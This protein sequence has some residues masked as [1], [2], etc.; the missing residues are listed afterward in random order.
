MIFSFLGIDATIFSNLMLRKYSINRSD[1]IIFAAL[2][3]FISLTQYILLKPVMST[4]LALDDWGAILTIESMMP[5]TIDK[6]LNY[7]WTYLGIH[8]TMQSFY[9]TTLFNFFNFNYPVYNIAGIILKIISI[10]SIFPVIYLI[11][12]RKSLAFLTT[13]I[14]AISYSATGALT[15]LLQ[16]IYYLG[17][18]FMNIFFIF[19]YFT[20]TKNS[21][22]YSILACLSLILAYWFAP[23]RI[24]PILLFILIVELFLNLKYGFKIT[25][26]KSLLRLFLFYTPILLLMFIGK[27]DYSQLGTPSQTIQDVYNGNW[28]IILNPFSGL[29]YLFLSSDYW[30]LFNN[31]NIQGFGD[32]LRFLIKENLFIILPFSVFFSFILKK[33]IIKYSFLILGINFV[34]SIIIYF[35]ATHHLSIPINLRVGWDETVFWR[36]Q[37]YSLFGVYVLTISGFCF[38]EYTKIKNNGNLLLIAISVGPILSL[39]FLFG[40]WFILGRVMTFYSGISRY[41]PFSSL[42]ASL[43]VAAVLIQAYDRVSKASQGVKSVTKIIIFFILVLIFI[44]SSKE[45]DLS[46][47]GSNVRNSYLHK[48][49]Q[50]NFIN[51]LDIKELKKKNN[52]LFYFDLAD[53]KQKKYF[54]EAFDLTNFGRWMYLRLEEKG[55][56]CIGS[57]D[58]EVKLKEAI[59]AGS[60]GYILFHPNS[61]CIKKWNNISSFQKDQEISFKPDDFYAFRVVGDKFINVTEEFLQKLGLKKISQ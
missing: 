36:Q 59:K 52:I 13:I 14:H 21:K 6:L 30:K 28:R 25:I 48:Q 3:T 18:T 61:Q 34:I 15:Y 12:K 22:A 16:G 32:Y 47:R 42:G 50:E 2:V 7:S 46:F 43:F 10:L 39:I 9:I 56:K 11:F 20:V 53:E 57:F 4:G 40:M 1:L 54:E 41:F 29:G 37:Y 35:V 49:F 23:G 38:W 31:I 44:F 19:Y 5:I 60:E 17:I 51:Q 24:Y 58:N 55:D 27:K 8:T 45:I 33:K 26:K